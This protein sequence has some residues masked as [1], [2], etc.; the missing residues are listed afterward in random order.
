MAMLNNQM[1]SDYIYIYII[2][3]TY[4]IYIDPTSPRELYKELY[5]TLK[6]NDHEIMVNMKPYKV[7]PPLAKLTHSSPG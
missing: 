2:I 5:Y 7:R 1:V 3:Y 6:N 4:I